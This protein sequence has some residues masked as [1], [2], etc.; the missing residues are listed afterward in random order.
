MEANL[1]LT[2]PIGLAIMAFLTFAFT[3]AMSLVTFNPYTVS[4]NF[5]K[6][7]TFIPGIKPGD[8]TEKYLTGI[9][10]RLSIFSAIYLTAISSI[11]YFEQ[12]AGLNRQMTFGGTTLIILV[13]VGV[14]TLGQL[15]ARDQTIKISKAKQRT[16]VKDANGATSTTGGLL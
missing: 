9:V 14:E 1:R 16:L 15:K 7:G 6:N 10:V 12:M 13:T 5:K 11:Q 4:D 3:I 2:A 8:E